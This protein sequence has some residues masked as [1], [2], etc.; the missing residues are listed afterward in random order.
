MIDKLSEIEKA[1]LGALIS[2]DNESSLE[3]WR[4]THLGRSS[5]L[6]QVFSGL[7]ALSK[8]ERPIIGQAANRA[9]VALEVGV[10]R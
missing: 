7:G 10:S 5:A 9:K 6:M 3:A 1:A 2:V 4:V 8:E